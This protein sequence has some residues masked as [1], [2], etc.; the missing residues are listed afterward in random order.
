MNWYVKYNS[1][2]GG[3]DGLIVKNLDRF[4]QNDQYE[5]E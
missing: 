4:Y 1:F 2:E 5:K 3:Y